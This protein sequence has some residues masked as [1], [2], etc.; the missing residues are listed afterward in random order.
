ML[1][2]KSILMII[3]ISLCLGMA[4]A[5]PAFSQPYS[6]PET[7]NG[8]TILK[9]PS[10]P[11]LG[12]K[13]LSLL[14]PDRF[15]MKHQYMMSFSSVGGNGSLMGMY[16]NTMEYRFNMPLTMRVKVAYQSQSAQLFGKSDGY[17]GQPN[18]DEGNV[19]VPAVD[20]IYRP[21]KNVS[22][23]FFYRNYSNY[24]NSY[25]PYSPYSSRYA[26][27]DWYRYMY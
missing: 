8:G 14:D 24:S 7:N 20:L 22:I 23:G 26:R 13:R 17:S 3:S 5:L 15:T 25:N 16:L 6:F 12:L 11:N 19:F 10:T 2:K 21:T 1:H 18:V 4:L 9:L 27:N